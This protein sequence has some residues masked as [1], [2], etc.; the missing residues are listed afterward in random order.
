MLR[1]IFGSKREEVTGAWRKLQSEG[2]YDWYCL[3][4]IVRVI[5]QGRRGGECMWHVWGRS[6]M[7]TGFWQGKLKE[8]CCKTKA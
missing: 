5:K 3:S 1:V 4:S 2:L 6:E 7:H 8:N